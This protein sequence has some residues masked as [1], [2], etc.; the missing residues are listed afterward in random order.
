M[1]PLYPGGDQ[2]FE[3]NRAG[4]QRPVIN[5]GLTPRYTNITQNC[6]TGDLLSLKHTASAGQKLI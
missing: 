1:L 4:T 2:G 3:I 6:N 5:P